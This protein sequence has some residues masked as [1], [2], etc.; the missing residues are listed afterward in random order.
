M[1][2]DAEGEETDV[3]GAGT[4]H[5]RTGSS[6]I[7]LLSASS[8]MYS[9]WRE[10]TEV[11]EVEKNEYPSQKQLLFMKS[12]GHSDTLNCYSKMQDKAKSCSAT[13]SVQWIKLNSGTSQT[14]QIKPDIIYSEWESPSAAAAE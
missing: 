5:L 14:L 3:R 11:W 10:E 9:A 4:G 12:R 1:D 2:G 7:L 6:T 8:I 13:T